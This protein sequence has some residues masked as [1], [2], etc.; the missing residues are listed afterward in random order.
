MPQGT[1]ALRLGR[2]F[3]AAQLAIVLPWLTVDYAIHHLAV[4]PYLFGF[5]A[6]FPMATLYL[7]WFAARERRAVR[8]LRQLDE[9][10]NEPAS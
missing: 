8:G 9:F 5:G 4:G 10:E 6:A 1:H 3:L 7:A 2:W